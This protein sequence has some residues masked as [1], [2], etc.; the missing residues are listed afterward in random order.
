M[1]CKDRAICKVCGKRKVTRKMVLI[2]LNN[3]I[4]RSYHVCYIRCYNI[5]IARLKDIV[6]RIE[7]V[8][9]KKA[10]VTGRP[11]YSKPKRRL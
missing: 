1:E 6:N 4:H 10:P 2:P 9:N 11:Q 8:I 3:N 5:E 7:E